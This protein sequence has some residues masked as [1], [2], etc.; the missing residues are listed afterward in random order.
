MPGFSQQLDTLARWRR[1]PALE[2]LDPP[3]TSFALTFDD[4][5]DPDA[6][7]AVLDALEAAGARATF[8][9]V[10][11]QVA[12]HPALAREVAARGHAVG[13]HGHRHVEHD[14]LADPRGDLDSVAALVAREAGVEASLYRPPY[15][16]FSN[17][18]YGH[19]L[20]AALTPVYWSGWGC[21]WE[22]IPAARI[23]DLA[24]RDLRPGAIL[25]LHD[26]PRYAYRDSALPT[27]EALPAILA[28]ARERGLEPVVLDQS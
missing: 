16:R 14:A 10:G 8:F 24:I 23:A 21:D 1:L 11:E 17:A 20:K 18:S 9:M 6:T 25:L 5:P 15:G 27:A 19:C 7:P 2:R 12:E 13:L 22:P 28:A 4:G 3:G 26:S